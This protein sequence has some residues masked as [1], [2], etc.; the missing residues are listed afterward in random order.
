METL[1]ELTKKA[2]YNKRVAINIAAKAL[3]IAPSHLHVIETGKKPRP[4]MDIIYKIAEYYG[5]PLDKVCLSAE[6]I[7]KD[8]FYKIIANQEL[9]QIIRNYKKEGG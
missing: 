2:R 6:R 8:I 3:K 9:L 4:K 5:V 7:P 1:A